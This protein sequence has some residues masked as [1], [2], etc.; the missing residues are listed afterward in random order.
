MTGRQGMSAE[1]L[2][3]AAQGSVIR[4]AHALMLALVALVTIPVLFLDFLFR[5][6]ANPFWDGFRPSSHAP[7]W[8][9]FTSPEAV[10]LYVLAGLT[11][12]NYGVRRRGVAN[13]V[14]E[15]EDTAGAAAKR[16]HEESAPVPPL[17]GTVICCSGG[18]IKSASFCM[19]ALQVLHREGVYSK[20]RDVVAVSGGGYAAAAF[21]AMAYRRRTFLHDTETT[22]FAPDS[23][24]LAEL[25]RRT[26][27]IG[28]PGR[29]RFDL[30]V[31]LLAGIALNVLILGAAVVVVAWLLGQHM[32]LTGMV[33]AETEDGRTHSSQPGPTVAWARVFA[34][35]SGSS[36][37]LVPAAVVVLIAV[38]CALPLLTL[39]VR[40][41]VEYGW[42]RRLYRVFVGVA[43]VTRTSALENLPSRL[44]ALAAAVFAFSVVMPAGAVL[45]HNWFVAGEEP[46][47]TVPAIWAAGGGTLGSL[48]G[49][50]GS[51]VK[52]IALPKNPTTTGGR[53]LETFRRAVAPFLAVLLFVVVVVAVTSIVATWFL[54]AALQNNHQP[55]WVGGAVLGIVVL[56]LRGSSGSPTTRR[57]YEDRLAYAY[58]DHWQDMPVRARCD[59][60]L[61]TVA[62]G[63]EGQWPGL[64]LVATANVQE[65]DVLPSGRGGTPFVLG[66]QVG[67]TSSQLPG[68]AALVDVRQYRHVGRRRLTLAGAIALSGAAVAPTAGRESKR[69][70]AYR[71][72]LAFANVRLGAWVR[73]PKYEGFR[74]QDVAPGAF[75]KPRALARANMALDHPNALNVVNEAWGRVSIYFPFLYVSD[76]GHYDNLGLAECLRL[77]PKQIIVLDGTGDAE[78]QFPVLGDVIATARMDQNVTV[79]LNP[80]PLCR[81]DRDHPRESHI[82]GK[83]RYG[84]EGTES[85]QIV[86]LRC[87]LPAQSSWDL[88]SFKLRNPD[89]PSTLQRFEMFDE[90]D[91]EAYRELGDLVARRAMHDIRRTSPRP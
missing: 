8:P 66:R 30:V 11:L 72:L 55:F 28:Q 81:G 69:I 84:D 67:L 47:F 63:A 59:V 70:G 42:G 24:E 5:R 21:A 14:R 6:P 39:S 54:T 83:A 25:R 88:T 79:D 22:P 7:V 74:R 62:K 57:F 26:N 32:A 29:T 52:G 10:V 61:Q 34:D 45:L 35:W 1:E 86:Y 85:T 27:Y 19:G 13:R 77:R 31:S 16:A 43:P 76:G 75:E 23:K 71:L 90:F 4:C 46:Q 40:P 15:H 58:L 3:F 37:L 60:R 12:L 78:D 68:G 91:F 44:I 50:V 9:F 48:W 89:Y 18:G 51:T 82:V 87:V 64:T 56:R 38:A 49:L 17:E 41:L 2:P 65:G 80:A 36:A 20:A 33:R 53:A 73:N